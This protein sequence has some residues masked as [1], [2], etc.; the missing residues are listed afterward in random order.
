M[1]EN[2]TDTTD[3]ARAVFA[4]LTP[5]AKALP[6]A[7]LS[8]PT[9][10]LL[11][12]GTM[13]MTLTGPIILGD[14]AKAPIRPDSDADADTGSSP[15]LASATKAATAA[16]AS[17][18]VV[19][20]DTVSGIAKRFGL[21]TKTVLALNG[22][23]ATSLIFPGQTLKLTNAAT[24]PA[25]TA[26]V[27]PSAPIATTPTAP[28][29]GTSYTI[30]RGDTVSG[31]AKRFGV[32]TQSILTAN[33]LAS[34]SIIYAGRTLVIPGTATTTPAPAPAP[35]LDAEPISSVTPTTPAPT[36]PAPSSP[37]PTSG[38]YVIKSGDTISK[39]AGTFGLTIQAVLDANGLTRTSIIYAGR[40]LVIPGAGGAVTA[41]ATG[42]TTITLL[43][44]EQS[45]NAATII[46]VG[47]EL[48]V[49]DYGI[50]IA[51]AT[52]MQE[53]SLRNIS[54]GH[55]DSVGLF[56]QRPSTGWGSIAQLTNA[57]HAAALFYGGPSNPN[58]GVTRGLLEISG[59]QN[60]TLTQAAQKVQISAY[61]DAYAK[62]ESSARSWFNELG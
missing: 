38:T 27:A 58:K 9:L 31:I 62:W 43:T 49:P 61:P 29:A 33:G 25:T 46:Q 48:G 5:R 1:I 22:L 2:E 44:A 54:Y 13:A 37:A 52:A 57:R 10:P 55:L 47:R 16:P 26:P 51:L 50:I 23:S 32:S 35:V 19:K 3:M 60:L 56:Q 17:Y 12:A 41:P 4:G 36:T 14:L 28:S 45:G 39:I 7:R 34:T 6:S 40:T 20:G 42:G 53:S 59:W 24:A 8:N 18:R 15:V 30:V 11:I 21:S